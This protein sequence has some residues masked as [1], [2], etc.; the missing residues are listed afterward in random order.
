LNRTKRQEPQTKGKRTM[1][2]ESVVGS[3]NRSVTIKNPDG[4]FKE[5]TER[6]DGGITVVSTSPGGEQKVGD[7][8]KGPSDTL[9]SAVR[10]N[11]R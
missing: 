3:G 2:K 4:S 10:I 7:G 6:N 9:D 8:A 5:I 11:T 1:G